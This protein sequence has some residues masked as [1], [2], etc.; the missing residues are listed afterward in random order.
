MN[1]LMILLCAKYVVH[2]CF[3]VKVFDKMGQK[4]T[5]VELNKHPHGSQVQ[6]ALKEMTGARTVSIRELSVQN[7]W[8][9]V[10]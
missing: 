8:V 7:S 9:Y 4:Y 5:V 1:S 2:E 3:C 6:D 10:T